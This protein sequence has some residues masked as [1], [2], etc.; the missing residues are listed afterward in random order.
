MHIA[1]LSGGD[2]WHVRD[3]QR[4]ASELG[5]ATTIIDFRRI[6]ASTGAGELGVENYDAVIVRTMP[7]G[8][9]D[10]V[11]FRMALLHAWEA[12]G[13]RIV[14]QP[15]ALETC[16]DKYLAAVRLEAAGL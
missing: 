10:Q 8:W 5:H 14:N 13:V 12:K 4:A 16:V 3:L 15:R 6:A 7:P 11:V 9:L 2:G 1:L